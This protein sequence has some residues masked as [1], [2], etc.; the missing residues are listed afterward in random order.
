MLIMGTM[1]GFLSPNKMKNIKDIFLLISVFITGSAVLII[2]VVAIRMLSPYYGNTIYTASSVIG[3]VLAA[4]SLGYYFGGALSD[5]YPYHKL[6]YSIIFISGLLVIFVHLLNVSMLPFFSLLFSVKTGPLISSLCIFFI[7]AFFL[8]TLS[9]FAIKLHKKEGVPLQAGPETGKAPERGPS[10]SGDQIGKRS[11]EVFFWSTLGSIAG[12]LASGFI[13]IPFLGIHAIIISTGLFLMLWG[14]CSFMFFHP[15]KSTIFIMAL[16]LIYAIFLTWFYLPQKPPSVLYEKDGVYEKIRISEGDW[17]GREARFLFQDMS[18]SAA[19]YL[20]SDELV[21]DYTKYYVLYKLFNP[22]PKNAL[23]IGGGAYSIPKTLLSEPSNMQV[24]VAEIEPELLELAKKYFR[25]EDNPRMHNYIED[26]RRLLAQSTQKYDIIFSDVYYSLFSVPMH[27][28]TKEFFDL[29]K[30]RLQEKGIFIGNFGGSLYGDQAS[31][32]VSEMKTFL[33]SFPNSYFFA[34]NSPDSSKVQNVI[35]LGINGV[36]K[37]DFTGD[38]IVKNGNKIISMLPEKNI[39]LVKLDF[40]KAR[41]LT[42]DFAPVEHLV[43]KVING[44]Q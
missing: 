42:D 15:K 17:K 31:L 33:E 24:D 43:G 40:S 6:F 10:A 41:E 16:F 23:V 22:T 32:V 21:Y 27:F 36:K 35:F 1:K 5:K 25:F 13:L 8:G 3:T 2:E 11:G 12:S 18:Y 29:A 30:S 34:V 26:G 14:F 19:M 28:T 37:L 9:P 44:W 7:P 20:D 39:D 4:L 38:E